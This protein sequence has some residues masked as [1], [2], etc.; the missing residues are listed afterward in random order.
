MRGV[1]TSRWTE[2]TIHWELPGNGT[3][4]F[5]YG[6]N[7]GD[8][9]QVTDLTTGATSGVATPLAGLPATGGFVPTKGDLT[10]HGS[11]FYIASSARANGDFDPSFGSLFSVADAAG[12]TAA[13]VDSGTFPKVGG[14]AFSSGGVF[15]GLDHFGGTLFT[16]DASL[17][18]VTASALTTGLDPNVDT[19]GGL[20]F[21]ANGKLYTSVS[22]VANHFEWFSIDP[23]TG[24]ATN[25]GSIGNY[26]VVGLALVGNSTPPP[27]PNVPE[28]ASFVLAGTGILA[29]L[30]LRRRVSN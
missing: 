2:T 7:N 13:E 21:G 3:S 23:A 12:H 4:L 28:P 15:Y 9:R 24:A 19:V 30:I 18:T 11:N 16:L 26:D 22:D 6:Q 27:P 29:V 17:G 10:F 20:V 25:I 14:L 5:L 8:L 1:R